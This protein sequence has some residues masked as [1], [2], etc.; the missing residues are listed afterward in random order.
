[1]RK[2]FLQNHFLKIF[3]M[4][5][6]LVAQFIGETLVK[7]WHTLEICWVNVA[8]IIV[9]LG[10]LLS[11]RGLNKK[12]ILILIIHNFNHHTVIKEIDS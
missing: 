9:L 4:I 3:F 8:P 2:F 5:F 7:F 6:S 1:M 10:L 12:S 11:Y